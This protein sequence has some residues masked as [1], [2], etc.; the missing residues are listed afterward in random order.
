LACLAMSIVVAGLR[1]AAWQISQPFGN[2]LNDVDIKLTN[3]LLLGREEHLNLSFDLSRTCELALQSD[4]DIAS[5]VI[6][7]I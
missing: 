6:S 3:K 7:S 1:A 5:F 4:P 2:R